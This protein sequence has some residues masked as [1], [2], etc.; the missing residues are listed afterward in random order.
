V[1][2]GLEA[3]GVGLGAD[4]NPAHW[5][6]DRRTAAVVAPALGRAV[7]AHA[8]VPAVE[9]WSGAGADPGAGGADALRGLGYLTLDEGAAVAIHR[10]LVE[11]CRVLPVPVDRGAP[12]PLLPAAVVPAA[13]AAVEEYGQRLS[14]ALHGFRMEQD[15]ESRARTWDLTVGLLVNFLP[16]RG[17][18]AGGLVA[19]YAAQALGLDGTWDNGPDR[20]LHFDRT[21]AVGEVVR[22][23]PVAAVAAIPAV[24]AQAAVGYDR[25]AALLGL[26]AAPTSPVSH[27][28]RPLV[29]AVE[30]GVTDLHGL[31]GKTDAELRRLL[32]R[33]EFSG[34]ADGTPIAVP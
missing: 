4:G 25:T 22:A 3:L 9:L 2:A 8:E 16:G 18:I 23:L 24:A 26:P 28:W 31:G 32:L 15:A 33:M 30:P 7:A 19:D 5:T 14:Y 12:A 21:D 17:G 29:N 6:V 20:G 13:Y 1:R 27:W 10:A 34:A 11:W